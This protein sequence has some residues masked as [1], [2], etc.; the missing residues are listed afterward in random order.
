VT[1]SG[2]IVW[3]HS[4]GR[5]VARDAAGVPLRM[6]GTI[7]DITERKQAE[8]Q[9]RAALAEKEVLLKE[10]HHRV[11]NNL[12]VISSLISL[13]ADN[14]TD[15]R[16]RAV[17]GDMRDR[18]R[19]MA[20][21]HEKLYQSGDLS[22]V[23]FSDYAAGLLQYLWRAHGTVAGRVDLRTAF[24]PLELTAATAVP[25][26]LLLNEL[27]SNALKHAFPTDRHGTVTAGVEHDPATGTVCL[28]VGDDGVGLPPDRDWRQAPSLGLRLVQM[29]ADQLGGMVETPAQAH[30]GTEFRV[31][32]KIE[33]N[34]DGQ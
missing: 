32:F 7:T 4:R 14:L 6:V 17:F 20:L 15:E 26:G 30:A 9:I 19:S 34:K 11:K 16:L 12:Q 13:Q 23:D 8:E 10:V 33:E 18:V 27:V 5:V 21:V 24:A 29:L 31:T 3:M 28:R 2:A 22:K 1:K 25:C